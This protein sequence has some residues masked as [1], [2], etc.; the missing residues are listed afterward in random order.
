MVSALRVTVTRH[1]ALTI[2]LGCLVPHTV[3]YSPKADLCTIRVNDPISLRDLEDGV[4]HLAS[5]SRFTPATCLIIDL[6]SC[7]SVPTA[8]DS[9]SLA[10]TLAS[11]MGARRTAILVTSMVHFGLANMIST[12]ANLDGGQVKAFQDTDKAKNWTR[13]GCE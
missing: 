5:D 13:S 4:Q 3:E 7:R 2:R 10:W 9:R 11:S 12:L 8:S 1:G 6:A